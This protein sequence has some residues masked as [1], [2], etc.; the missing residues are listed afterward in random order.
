MPFVFEVCAPNLQ[1]AVAAKA[2]GAHR[3]ELCAALELGG[4]TPSLGLIVQ[5][6]E[7]VGIPVH[8]LIRPRDGNFCYDGAEAALMHREVA[9]CRDAGAAGVVIGALTSDNRLDLP[10]LSTL[11]DAA[12]TMEVTCHRAFDFTT[13]PQEALEQL[14]ELK[15]HRLL[16]SGQAPTAFEG[17][18]LLQQ[19]VGQ[20]E[21]RIV[22]MPG[23]G[24]DAGNIRAIAGATGA[25]HF[26]FSAK[27]MVE[28]PAGA[29]PGLN[30]RYIAADLAKISEIMA[31]LDPGL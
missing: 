11:R 6:I 9:L 23:S 1:S 4:L 16:S 25:T 10:L 2:A 22:I 8:A 19:L 27:T 21:G 3:I 20:A 18:G 31:A 26:H 24:I 5:I 28:Q 29:L 13:D 30:N 15:F 7:T 12:G 14:I 17:R